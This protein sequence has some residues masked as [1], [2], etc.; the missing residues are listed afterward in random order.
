MRPHLLAG[1]ILEGETWI[2]KARHDGVEV[3]FTGRG[4]SNDRAESLRRIEPKALPLAWA[5]QVHSA[6]AL[7]ARPGDC[8]EGDALF[9]EEAG[10]VLSV[11]T[12]DCVPILIAGPQ[13]LA[14]IHAGWRGIA[15][16]IVA[17]TLERLQGP[18]GDWTAWVGPAIGACCYEVG[19]EVAERVV[20]ASGPE[21]AVSGPAGRPHLDLPQAARLQLAAAGVAEVIVLPRCT[22]CDEATLWSYRRE[23]KRAGRNLAF[24]WRRV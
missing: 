7:P 8:G 1:P 13:S 16:G 17:A 11:V 19:E 6:A 15:G 18:S 14:A 21:V 5:K 2:W 24:I 23:G 12:A 10:L 4:P 9:T 22:R 3:R 20:A